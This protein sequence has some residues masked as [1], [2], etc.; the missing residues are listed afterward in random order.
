MREDEFAE[1]I[2]NTLDLFKLQWHHETDS[3]KSKRG[4]P[5]YCIAGPYGVLF[6]EIKG[7]GGKASP[8]QKKWIAALEDATLDDGATPAVTAYVAWPED[9]DRVLS[10]LKRIAGRG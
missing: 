10:D 4:F 6:I 3:R 8:E 2:E 1:R 7:K 9:W 5:D